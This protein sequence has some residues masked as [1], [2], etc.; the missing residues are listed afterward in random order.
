MCT[1]RL[2]VL[3]EGVTGVWFIHLGMCFCV[4]SF[5]CRPF[6]QHGK[7]CFLSKFFVVSI[8]ECHACASS[9]CSW[10]RFH[11]GAVQVAPVARARDFVFSRG[12]E[13]YI[14]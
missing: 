12:R 1:Q 8:F 13:G 5:P 11:L 6:A 4:A 9:S 2:S 10:P 7:P 14:S 3:L